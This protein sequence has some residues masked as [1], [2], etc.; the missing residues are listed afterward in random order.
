MAS[1]V[2]L[3]MCLTWAAIPNPPI[4]NPARRGAPFWPELVVRR[5]S[6]TEHSRIGQDH[7]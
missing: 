5:E 4:V 3:E 1:R 6:L 2:V 7:P